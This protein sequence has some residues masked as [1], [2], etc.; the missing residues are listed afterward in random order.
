M[1]SPTDKTPLKNR[2]AWDHLQTVQRARE[3][4]NSWPGWKRDRI[5]FR[6]KSASVIPSDA[7]PLEM[8]ELRKRSA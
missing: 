2:T 3:I 6:D 7:A 1:S 4:V 5:I 8:V